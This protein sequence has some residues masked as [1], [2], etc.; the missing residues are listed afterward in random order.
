VAWLLRHGVRPDQVLAV[1]FTNRAAAELKERV[2]ALAQ[3]RGLWVSTFHSACAR[4]LRRHADRLGY[5]VSF[6]IYDEEDRGR[7]ASRVLREFGIGSDRISRAAAVRTI[8]D[9]NSSGLSPEAARA[10]CWSLLDEDKAKVYERYEQLLRE[11]G[12]MDFDDLL[13]QTHRLFEGHDD[14]LAQYTARLRHVLVD[15]YQDTNRIQF[16]LARALASGTRNLC[17][18]GDPDQSIYKWRGADIRNILDFEEH[19]PDATVV[20]LERNYR[21]TANV[22]RT[23]GNLIRHNQDRRQK[24]LLTDAASGPLVRVVTFDGADE[25]GDGVAKALRAWIDAGNSAA[26]AAVFYRV[27]SRSRAIERSLRRFDIPYQ[28]VR[29]VE[30]F[31]RAEVKDLVAWLRIIANPRDR[32]AFARLVGAPARG[33]GA[34][35]VAKVLARAEESGLSIREQ[36]LLGPEDSAVR[37]KAGKALQWAG[38]TLRQLMDDPFTGVNPLL[39]EILRRTEYRAW[40]ERK[41]PEDHQE[42]WENVVELLAAAAGHDARDEENR[43][44]EGFLEEVALVSDQDRFD[45]DAPRVTLMT[46][47]TSKGLEFPSVY[48]VGVEEGVLPHSRS[49]EDPAAMEEERRLLFVGMTR[50]RR[51]LW[52][53]AGM[54]ASGWTGGVSGPSRFLEELGTE[55][56]ERDHRETTPRAV[57][58]PDGLRGPSGGRRSGQGAMRRGGAPAKTDFLGMD[59]P[60]GDFVDEMPPETVASDLDTGFNVGDRVHHARFGTGRVRRLEQRRSSLRATVEFRMGV[61]TLDLAYARLERVPDYDDGTS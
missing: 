41:W 32:E 61:K 46:L 8:S 44:L 52:L 26:D 34:G 48:V 42:R 53:S 37:G 17:A 19:Y 5:P 25:E 36:L 40:L 47:H 50:A 27:N 43:G 9:W 49:A 16:L 2:E 29:G 58:T 51:S 7:L 24:E 60:A 12:A 6:S 45:P 23:A 15:E 54:R 14:V 55:G 57:W 35:S 3:S 21:S 38:V 33:A 20:R 11:G 22:L 56:M 31:Q 59:P 28:L 1:T 4:I 18:T 13:I 30:F 39:E 10:E